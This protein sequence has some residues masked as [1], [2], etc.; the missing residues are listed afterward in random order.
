MSLA[1]EEFSQRPTV[2]FRCLGGPRPT[3]KD[4]RVPSGQTRI[5]ATPVVYTEDLRGMPPVEMM[6]AQDYSPSHDTKTYLI[7]VGKR[8][9][10]LYPEPCTDGLLHYFKATVSAIYDV[11]PKY[12]VAWCDGD[13]KHRQLHSIFITPSKQN[14]RPPAIDFV[15]ATPSKKRPFRDYEME[16]GVSNLLYL[17]AAHARLD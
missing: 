7:P 16:E 15:T 4:A 10:A 6:V 11:E 2:G 14:P 12:L 13:L 5:S 3:H 17:K 8:C 9:F 1:I